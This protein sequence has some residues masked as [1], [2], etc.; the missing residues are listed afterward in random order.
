MTPV[1]G[2]EVEPPVA[3]NSVRESPGEEII[4]FIKCPL[5][6]IEK[7]KSNFFSKHLF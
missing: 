2:A 3:Q 7:L 6:L 1:S 5:K 4:K